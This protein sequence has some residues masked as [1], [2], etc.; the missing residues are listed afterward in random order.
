[1]PVGGWDTAPGCIQHDVPGAEGVYKAY[2]KCADY[3]TFAPGSTLGTL[4]DGVST[5]YWVL[6]AIGILVMFLALIGWV[7]L[8]NKKLQAQAALLRRAGMGTRAP[9]AGPG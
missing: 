8:E 2:E 7:V 1:M 9:S 4:S 6:T 3:F 5:S